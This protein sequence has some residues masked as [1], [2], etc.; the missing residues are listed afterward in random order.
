[1][2]CVSIMNNT[3]GTPIFIVLFM[4]TC[5]YYN[6]SFLAMSKDV[7]N[8]GLFTLLYNKFPSPSNAYA[9]KMITTFIIYQL[10]LMRIV[11]GKEFKATITATG[12]IPTYTA[13]GVQC[14]L[15]TIFTLFTLA[16]YKVWNPADVYDHFGEL[17]L[18]SNILA[19]LLCS[20]LTFKV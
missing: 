7:Y 20:F 2:L 16:Y 3:I 8:T 15:I 17:L 4:G 18:N 5:I 14:Y 12:F 9:W 10:I 1:M 6:G 11:P 13:N 19:L